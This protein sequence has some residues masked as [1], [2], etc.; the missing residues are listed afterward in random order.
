MQSEW[1]H[2]C[3]CLGMWETFSF[4]LRLRSFHPF[5]HSPGMR[6]NLPLA[7]MVL[8]VTSPVCFPL[9]SMKAFF[10]F[11]LIGIQPLN[12]GSNDSRLM[13]AECCV[14]FLAHGQLRVYSSSWCHTQLTQRPHLWPCATCI[15]AEQKP[16][17]TP[18]WSGTDCCRCV[19]KNTTLALE[20]VVHYL[21][22]ALFHRWI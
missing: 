10:F 14:P 12:L 22:S 19:C 2:F 1:T 16:L 17:S 6:W 15:A 9:T 7:F 3:R 18:H 5:Q 13:I 8:D 20:G 11:F 4:V 21:W